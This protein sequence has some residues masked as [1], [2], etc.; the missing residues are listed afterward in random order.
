MLCC[1]VCKAVEIHTV[2]F[3]EPCKW[4]Q[5]V[6]PE[7]SVSTRQTIRCYD[8]E[9]D[10]IGTCLYFVTRMQ[11]KKVGE[12]K[13]SILERGEGRQLH[14]LLTG[15]VQHKIQRKIKNAYKHCYRKH[16]QEASLEAYEIFKD[17]IIIGDKV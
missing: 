13:R 15:W 9:C 5:N 16:L 1:E 2:I 17:N 12:R 14:Q 6:P 4:K 7:R 11:E 3:Q 8:S 10:N